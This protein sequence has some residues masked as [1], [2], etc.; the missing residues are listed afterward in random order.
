[1][2]YDFLK[3]LDKA[4]Q[5]LKAGN[6]RLRIE[7]R[8][9]KLVLRGVFPSKDNHRRPYQQR[10]SLDLSANLQGLKIAIAKAKEIDA[11]LMLGS[12]KWENYQSNTLKSILIKDA[13]AQFQKHY[14]NSRERNE[15]SL[16]TWNTDYLQCF[17]RLPQNKKLSSH[18]C[19]QETLKTSPN[20]RQR[21]RFV[22]GY[23]ALLNYFNIDHNL[24]SLQGNY[25]LSSVNPRDLPEDELILKYCETIDNDFWQWA[26]RV[27]TCYGL[28][29]HEVFLCD[30]TD[31]PKCLI[32]GG[33][34]GERITYPLY[35][36]WAEKWQLNNFDYLPFLPSSSSQ[37][38]KKIA[39]GFRK[40]QIPFS[41]YTL[42]HC[43]ARRAF[44]FGFPPNISAIFMGHS[45]RVHTVVYQRWIKYDLFS[46]IYYRLIS[47]N[48]T[49]K[50]PELIL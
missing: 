12:F 20:S 35:P 45:L 18:L 47:E 22:L 37:Y 34:T 17:K 49:P 29:N 44:D 1:M 11:K 50:P 14:F 28:R 31:Y 26:F 6:I 48:D 27:L 8:G 2:N 38:G 36:E 25:S 21:K 24:K 39:Y 7:Q 40:Y 10:L 16:N 15:K 13:I 33:K 3:K 23:S 32:K 42:R 46:R 19:E 43:W 9:S 5:S 4:N 30:L 41:P